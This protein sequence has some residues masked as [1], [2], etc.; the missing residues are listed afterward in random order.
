MNTPRYTQGTLAGTFKRYSHKKEEATAPE[1]ATE[2]LRP[3]PKETDI[4]DELVSS[5][6]SNLQSEC[7]KKY[8]LGLTKHRDPK[9]REMPS[10]RWCEYGTSNE[11]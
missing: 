7:L 5:R 1:A 2:L 11:L 4:L 9:N 6:C 8:K 3:M 10:L